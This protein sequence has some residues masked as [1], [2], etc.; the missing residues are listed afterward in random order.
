MLKL[1]FNKINLL[2]ILIIISISGCKDIIPIDTGNTIHG[3]VTTL[4]E[5][6]DTINDRNGV[7]VI[8]SNTDFSTVTDEYGFFEFNNVPIG[9]YTIYCE[10]DG[11]M[12][13]GHTMINTG[14][15]DTLNVHCSI[16]KTSTTLIT[17]YRMEG[18]VLFAKGTITHNSPI[19][20]FSEYKNWSTDWDSKCP[21]ILI[22]CSKDSTVSM[23]THYDFAKSRCVEGTYIHIYPVFLPSGEEFEINVSGRIQQPINRET[24]Y[25]IAYGVSGIM[26]SISPHPSNLVSLT[27]E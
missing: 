5:F 24:W 27:N 22:M 21:A 6:S 20:D 12:K 13:W 17:N 3:T 15:E 26:S 7:K 10:K 1:I 11:Y 9:E 4:S 8:I 18:D 2:Y 19:S 16:I 14:I 23:E 25:Y